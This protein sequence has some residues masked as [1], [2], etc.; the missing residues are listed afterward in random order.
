[1]KIQNICGAKF[2]TTIQKNRANV[3]PQYG[4]QMPKALSIDTVS[5]Q[6]KGA[7]V[8]SKE[9]KAAIARKEARALRDARQ[10]AEAKKAPE[11]AEST[12]K[13]LSGEERTWGVPK[14]TATLIH[15]KLAAPQKKIKK[16][17][18]EVFGDLAVNS[19]SPKN[20]ILK[21]ADRPK[22]A[23][24]IMEKSSTRQWNSTREI[25][26]NMTDL[27][28][29]K[30][31]LNHKTGKPE[32]EMVL[33]RLIPLI[34]TKQVKLKEIELQRPEAI[35]G[36][37]EKEQ[38]EFDYVSKMFLDK[39]EDAQEEVLNG[40]ETDVTKI[41]LIDRPVPK[42]TKGHYCALHLLLEPTEKGSRVF[43]LQIMGAKMSDGKSLDDKRFK[44]FDGKEIDKMYAPL[45]SLWQRLLPDENAAAKERFL[46]YYKDANFQLRKDE[47]Q[48]YKTQ[49]LINRQNGF[50]ISLRN[51]DLPP[52]YDLNEQYRIMR[53]CEKNAAPKKEKQKREII[54]KTQNPLK[55]VE[56]KLISAEQ[57]IAEMTK[58]SV[59]K[60][61]AKYSPKHLNSGKSKAKIKD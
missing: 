41:K 18:S 51:Y 50:F 55:K 42:Y 22:S 30:I 47:I 33:D 13:N 5:F 52:E 46:Q 25:M 45:I 35:K 27:N 53:Q 48:E 1:M 31:V 10:L 54:Q 32:A 2:N 24:S 11:K 4:I 60:L 61:I 3:I 38:E 43:E 36:Y 34:R 8:I 56:T 7:K 44:F 17:M 26:D 19:L 57:S 6:A 28:G 16:F 12:K 59:Q 39:L 15:E 23:I 20:P 14:A 9:M 29:A 37:S 49:R 21:I 58:T 40:L